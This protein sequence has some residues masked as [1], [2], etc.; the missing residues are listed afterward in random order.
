MIHE[1]QINN[2]TI[3]NDLRIAVVSSR[4]GFISIVDIVKCEPIRMIKLDIPVTHAML[5]TY[6]YY[7]IWIECQGNKQFCYSL[8]GQLLKEYTL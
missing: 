2:I 6:P 4:D 8:N 7:C 1:D 5:V 3:N